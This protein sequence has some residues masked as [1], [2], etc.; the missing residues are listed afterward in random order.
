MSSGKNSKALRSLDE[1][2]KSNVQSLK[3]N[4]RKKKTVMRVLQE[5]HLMSMTS[6]DSYI[7]NE[8]EHTL[9]HHYSIFDKINASTVRKR[10]M[11]MQGSHGPS[12]VDAKDWR[13]WLSRF[14]QASTYL[15][16]ALASF[17]RKL[18]TEQMKDLT[19]HSAY[20][21]IPLDKTPDVRP[22]EMGEVIIAKSGG[23]FFDASETTS[24]FFS[25][26]TPKTHSIV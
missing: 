26:L 1:S 20:R 24:S 22:I 13:R 15:C 2:Q 16:M 18:A 19:P 6:E 9:E 14:G 11:V 4:V 10:A 3:E 25:S 17:A 5:K 12:G 8:N 7:I 21:L 23:T